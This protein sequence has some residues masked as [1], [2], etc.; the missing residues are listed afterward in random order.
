MREMFIWEKNHVEEC[1]NRDLFI[2]KD[3]LEIGGLLPREFI[4]TL[5]IKSWTSTEFWWADNDYEYKQANYRV[6][7]DDITKTNLKENSFDVIFSTN[8]FEHIN[9]FEL[10]LNN[11]YNLLRE[12]GY[13]SALFGPIWSSYKGHHIWVNEGDKAYTFNDNY[14]PPYGHLIY[15]KDDLAELLKNTLPE[16]VVDN[17][18]YQTYKSDTINRLFYEDYIE[19]INKS[20]FKIYEIRDW[21]KTVSSDEKTQLILKDKYPDKNFNTVSM[22]ILLKK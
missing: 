5:N 17:I 2:G 14:I 1:L 15:D 11:M 7:Y 10:A 21:H 3:V 8:C 6:I 12:G 20:K 4:D 18:I 13:L 9:N 16:D 19:I 22:K